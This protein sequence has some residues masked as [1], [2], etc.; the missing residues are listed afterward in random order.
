M[1]S[2]LLHRPQHKFSAAHM[3]VFADGTKE[4]LHGHNY[5]LAIQIF[6]REAAFPILCDFAVIKAGLLFV[7]KELN[8]RTLLA[9][10]NPFLRIAPEQ[11][12]GQAHIRV[13]HR[14]GVYLLPES[15]VALLPLDNI[16]TEQLA[17]YCHTRLAEYL[18]RH[19]PEAVQAILIEFEVCVYELPGQGAS[20]RASVNPEGAAQP[21]HG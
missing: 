8:E 7:C 19:L 1:Q 13:Q 20:F 3:T 12:A 4:R 5:Q 18:R 2:I 11:I 10:N 6:L 17:R 15:D 14:D 16:T 9:R 21:A